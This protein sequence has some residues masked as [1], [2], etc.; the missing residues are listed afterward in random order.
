MKIL[1]DDRE[2]GSVVEEFVKILSKDDKVESCRL[3][4][5][6]YV[7]DNVCIERK[8][9]VDFCASIID[10]RLKEQSERMVN[11]FKYNYVIVSGRFE[12]NGDININCVLGMI[13]SLM[14][15]GINVTCVADDKQLVYLMKR[16]FERHALKNEEVKNNV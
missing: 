14:V 2:D 1:I 11:N 3:K 6:D 16:I 7:M 15:K 4:T 13:S 12:N 5:G 10:G 8:S 9:A